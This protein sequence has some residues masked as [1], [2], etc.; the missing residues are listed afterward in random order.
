VIQLLS[1]TT[2]EHLVDVAP[3]GAS[4]GDRDQSTS[5]LRN[6]VAQFG[7]PKG[8]VVGSDS[9]SQVLTS[10]RSGTESGTT[11]L[12]GGVLKVKGVVRILR[13]GGI[14][15]PVVGGSG[16]FAGAKGTMFV[17]GI[18]GH[19]KLAINIYRLTYH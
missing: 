15:V 7:K 5:Q 1:T 16:R 6:A 10:A 3:K 19:P 17:Y 11:T 12:P 2:S 8:A 18:S 9:A 13:G 4:A 14:A